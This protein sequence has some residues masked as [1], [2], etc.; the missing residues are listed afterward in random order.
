VQPAPNPKPPLEFT[1]IWNLSFG[2][3]GI[4]FGWGLQMANMSAIFE[5]LGVQE[6]NLAILWVAAPVTGLLVQPIIG[7]CS[8][9]TWTRLGRRKPYILFGAIAA[10][11]ALIAMPY[12]PFWWTAAA[13]LW[14]LDT[15]VNVSMEPFRAFVA[16]VLPESQ[17]TIGYTVQSLL[18]GLGAVL[19]S[20]LPFI[21]R[22]GFG[23]GASTEGPPERGIPLNV[24]LAFL[25]GASAY[26]GAVLYTIFT[27]REYP[28]PDADAFRR[29]QA[30]SAGI[31]AFFRETIRG[32]AH[33]PSTMRQ[34]ALVQFFT[35]FGLFCMW[36]Y[37]SVAI[38]ASIFKGEPDSP[39]F[40]RGV[41]WG[42][43]CF[44]VYN[45]VGLAFSF[46][47]LRAVRYL[48]PKYIHCGCLMAGGVGLASTGMVSH[49]Y[50]LFIPMIGIGIAWASILS[51]PYAMLAPSLPPEKMGFYMGIFNFFITIPQIA[52]SGGLTLAMHTF[53]GGNRMAAVILGGFSI[54][55]ASFLVLSVETSQA[56]KPNPS[57]P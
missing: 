45:G 39:A 46:V 16:D 23:I 53:L 37:F 19:S 54:V 32:I 22:Q 35:W 4:Q 52:A 51:M 55:I 6:Q 31:P 18:I 9:R 7:Y 40:E 26:L 27:T 28:P 11:A 41:D 36:L 21:L 44:A 38:A 57:P 50:A 47:L 8:D 13:L 29:R 30:E 15:A 20:A 3:A 33:M 25:L 1:A 2:F 42:G 5:Y 48:D 12:S 10:S 24:Q 56:P 43:V 17:H 14:I 49:P 34:L